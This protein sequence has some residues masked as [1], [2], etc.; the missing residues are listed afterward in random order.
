MNWAHIG[1]SVL[2][3][4]VP[5]GVWAAL[6]VVFEPEG[7]WPTW[8]LLVGGASGVAAMKIG[9]AFDRHLTIRFGGNPCRLHQAHVGPCHGRRQA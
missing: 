1:R 9:R 5:L 7:G 2:F 4:L 3:A 6:L 8:L